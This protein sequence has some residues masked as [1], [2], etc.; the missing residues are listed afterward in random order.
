[1]LL[2]C[3]F[4]KQLV[5]LKMQNVA[6]N[7]CIDGTPSQY[8][9]DFIPEHFLCKI[10]PFGIQKSEMQIGLQ[11]PGRRA[12][13]NVIGI[14]CPPPLLSCNRQKR[15]A[16]NLRYLQ[17][18]SLKMR[19]YDNYCQLGCG[20]CYKQLKGKNYSQFWNAVRNWAQ[21]KPHW[22]KCKILVTA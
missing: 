12:I 2:F 16:R 7:S 5:I 15:S 17:S 6:T 18:T 13:C 20:V 21:S 8:F 19:L 11:I 10:W 4:S 3:L 22:P 9:N 14:I 1:M